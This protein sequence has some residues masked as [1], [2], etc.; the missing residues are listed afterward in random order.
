VTPA[1]DPVG[2]DTLLSRARKRLSR[3]APDEAHEAAQRGDLLIDIRPA[4]QRARDGLIPG[5]HLVDRNVLE[6]RLDPSSPDRDP[7]LARV[8]R[9]VIVICDE[10]YQ[11]SLAAATLREFGVDATDVVGGAQE[12]VRRGLATEP[13]VSPAEH[14]SKV[15]EE[16]RPNQV[17]WYEPHPS[18]SIELI[19][20]A[21]LDRA[22]AI[23]D[24]GGGASGLARSLLDSGFAD[25]TVADLSGEALGH[26]QRDLGG[27]AEA[28]TW[29]QG[30]VLEHAFGRQF[31][32]WH[33]RAVFHFM[34]QPE[35]GDRYRAN[36][37][38]H[39]RPGGHVVIAT[40]GSDGPTRCSGL[41][42]VRFG[43]AELS[44]ALGDGF[45]PITHR[46]ADHVTPSGN[47]QQFLYGLY[48]REPA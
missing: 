29:V 45:R 24:V 32:L 47:T 40:F 23:V 4:H 30:D 41:P 16:H 9:R 15:Y 43:A 26:A 35:Q 11:S 3:L 8:D 34:T 19:G 20:E 39:L 14:W 48:M 22:A 28:V 7:A 36:L 2:V 33:D 42:T 17:S 13:P 46:I 18:L 1:A 6:W 21:G 27:R 25:V 37:L 5:A 44:H 38:R 12:W 10:G 31:D